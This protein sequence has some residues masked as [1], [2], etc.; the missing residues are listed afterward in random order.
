MKF[1]KAYDNR[2]AISEV[3]TAILLISIILTISV[4]FIPNALHSEQNL[5][6]HISYSEER[7]AQRFMEALNVIKSDRYATDLILWI[8]NYGIAT[9]V[10]QLVINGT[11]QPV[12]LLRNFTTTWQPIYTMNFT[13]YWI[14]EWIPTNMNLFSKNNAN[15]TW[16]VN[17]NSLKMNTSSTN[18][19]SEFGYVNKNLY[20][21]MFTI[22]TNIKITSGTFLISLI[23]K[24]KTFSTGIIFNS[25]KNA[26]S[27]I[28]N[29]NGK[30]NETQ[31]YT[32]NTSAY[33]VSISFNSNYVQF[34]ILNISSK[35]YNVNIPYYEYN[36]GYYIYFA[37]LSSS[38]YTSITVY[39]FT[40]NGI[41][42]NPITREPT[43]QQ[44][45]NV[46]LIKNY[47]WMQ[48]PI[49]LITSTGNVWRWNI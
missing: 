26:V 7:Q 13:Q 22:N 38:S 3:I 15:V 6:S 27:I 34:Q 35:K 41:N 1:R 42:I 19:L 45:I 25:T 11:S 47:G 16:S 29:N 18:T 28:V 33:N 43:L 5:L 48:K 49:V 30:S 23:S 31:I 14:N 46:I 40:I 32:M 37:L 44:G 4:I 17:L 10:S 39:S 8:Y 20:G 9:N 21:Y 24:D 36:S 12:L 2:F